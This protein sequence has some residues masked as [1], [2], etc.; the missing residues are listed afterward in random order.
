MH[1]D[2]LDKISKILS[3]YDL[4]EWTLIG[5]NSAREYRIFSYFTDLSIMPV[6]KYVLISML[7]TIEQNIEET[8]YR[9]EIPIGSC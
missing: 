1:Q 7:K 2:D 6:F 8:N 3:K 5:F 9:Y 4:I